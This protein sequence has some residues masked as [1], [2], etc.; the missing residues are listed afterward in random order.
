VST[1]LTIHLEKPIGAVTALETEGCESSVKTSAS[2]A[3]QLLQE[4][5][6]VIKAAE[7]LQRAAQQLTEFQQH[8]FKQARPHIARL[9][10]EIAEKILRKE[11]DKGN[12]DIEAIIAHA[13]ESSPTSEQIVAHLNPADMAQVKKALEADPGSQS[14]ERAVKL[15][16]LNGVRF[17]ADPGVRRAECLL[18]TPQGVI[19][20]LIEAQLKRIAEALSGA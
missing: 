17:F 14:S 20:S 8:I 4:R 19:E 7:A 18:E 16:L 10:L 15:S 13:I 2:A 9:S 3:Q 11:I 5:S 12:Y 6:D 1:E